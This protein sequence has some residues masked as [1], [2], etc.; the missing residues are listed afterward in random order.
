M[1]RTEPLS[2]TYEDGRLT[3]RLLGEIDHHGAREMREKIDRQLYLYHPSEFVLSL[4]RANFM[5]SSGLGLILGRYTVCRQ[6]AC[7]MRLT[8]A[9]DQM[10]R[11]FRLAGLERISGLTIDGLPGKEARP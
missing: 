6:F 7:A 8:D 10:L 1:L 9:S 3:V 4:G 2:A 11:I 5:D